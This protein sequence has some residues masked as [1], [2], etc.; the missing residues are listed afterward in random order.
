[1]GQLG[2]PNQVAAAT[3]ALPLFIFITALANLFGVGGASPISPLFGTG[4]PP[5]SRTYRRFLH[6]SAIA[7]S[8][9]YGI[10]VLLLRPVLLPLAGR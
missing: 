1:M 9:I 2:D 10:A 7:V 3:V 8:L 6:L 4:R 5:K